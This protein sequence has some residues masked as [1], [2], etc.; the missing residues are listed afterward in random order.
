[1]IVLKQKL[2]TG[3][4]NLNFFSFFFFLVMCNL[5]QGLRNYGMTAEGC[6]PRLDSTEVKKILCIVIVTLRKQKTGFMRT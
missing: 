6:K 3:S 5:F 2:M 4:N 1:M